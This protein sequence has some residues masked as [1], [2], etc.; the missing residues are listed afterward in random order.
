MSDEDSRFEIK[1][2]LLYSFAMIL[3]NNV[4]VLLCS[5]ACMGDHVYNYCPLTVEHISY[6]LQYMCTYL[7]LLYNIL[8]IGRGQVHILIVYT[9]E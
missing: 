9:E 1:V 4:P 8:Y 5:Y 6:A 7:I 2:V 3:L